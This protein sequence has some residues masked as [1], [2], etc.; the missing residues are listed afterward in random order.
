MP[1]RGDR[2]RVDAVVPVRMQAREPDVDWPFV[3]LID[4]ERRLDLCSTIADD[5]SGSRS[6]V[7]Q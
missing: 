6:T 2:R 3:A 4:A 1:S 7:P 5:L